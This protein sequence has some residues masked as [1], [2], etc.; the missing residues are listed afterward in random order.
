MPSIDLYT[1]SVWIL[2][3]LFAVTLH[4]AAHGLVAWR[5]GDDTAYRLG[6]V[7]ANPF[8][9]I[10][11]F[12]TVILPGILLLSGSSFLF[13]YAKPVPVRVANLRHQRRDSILVSAAGPGANLLIAIVSA[14]LL[15]LVALLPT[16]T[17]ALWT[18]RTLVNSVLLNVSLAVFNMLPIPPLDGSR[19]VLGLLPNEL[20]RAYQHLFRYG[21]LLVIGIVLLLPMIGRNLGVNLDIIGWMMRGPVGYLLHVIAVITGLR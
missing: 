12:G 18:H 13:G 7:S 10:D 4:E 19:V 20:A 15:H 21:L 11:P 9:H 3:V 1:V 6:R 8:R 17:A 2:P 16:E 5:L 14:F